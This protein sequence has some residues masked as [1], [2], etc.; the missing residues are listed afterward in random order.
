MHAQTWII[1]TRVVNILSCCGLLGLQFWFLVELLLRGDLTEI[2]LQIFVP[3]FL[4]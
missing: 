3:V 4:M 2:L 1:V